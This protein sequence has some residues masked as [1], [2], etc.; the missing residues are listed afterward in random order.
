M[1]SNI[2]FQLLRVY[3][4]FQAER[5]SWRAVIYLNLIRSFPRIPEAL[6]PPNSAQTYISTANL[7]QYCPDDGIDSCL[8]IGRPSMPGS[9]RQTAGRFKRYG[10]H[11]A[12]PLELEQHLICQLSFP[13]EDDPPTREDLNIGRLPNLPM[14]ASAIGRRMPNTRSGELSLRPTSRWKDAFLFRATAERQQTRNNYTGEV[15]GWW[16]DPNDPVHVLHACAGGQWGIRALWQDS[17]MRTT[18]NRRRVRMEESAGF[19]LDD[20]DHHGL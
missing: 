20:V 4:Q 1:R 9:S 7:P 8:H 6:L 10:Q 12:P 11:L 14:P 3:S 5:I 17:S 2:E 13:E 19:Y 15:G 18:L 16:E